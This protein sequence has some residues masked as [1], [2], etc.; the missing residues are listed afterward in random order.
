MIGPE[1][2]VVKVWAD[3]PETKVE[4]N[5]KEALQFTQQMLQQQQQQQEVA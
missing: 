1:G 5:P 4:A 2:K 3:I